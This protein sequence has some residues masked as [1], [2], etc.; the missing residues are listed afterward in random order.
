MSDITVLYGGQ[1]WSNWMAYRIE[2]DLQRPA[3]AF[4]LEVRPPSSSPTPVTPGSVVEVQ[5]L[6]QT[7]LWGRVDE[8]VRRWSADGL[9]LELSGRDAGGLLVDASADPGWVWKDTNL[10]LIASQVATYVGMVETPEVEVDVPVTAKVEPGESCWDLVDR[11]VRAQ[12]MRAWVA[13]NGHLVV[14]QFLTSGPASA[15]LRLR[16]SGSTNNIHE[17]EV[18]RSSAD[19]ASEVTV[20]AQADDDT[21][22]ARFRGTWTDLEYPYS[23]PRVVVDDTVRSQD[24][25]DARAGELGAEGRASRFEANATIKGHVVTGTTP[26]AC[27]TLV[28]LEVEAEAISGLYLVAARTFIRDTQGGARTELRLVDPQDFASA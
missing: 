15:E 22:H 4:S 5:V 10:S 13:E 23:K 1:A 16:R 20:L 25:A 14:S 8:V 27:N 12:G 18:R 24:E 9:S 11:L 26:W 3:A 2:Q 7:V 17:L 19:G 28:Q 6:G 21:N